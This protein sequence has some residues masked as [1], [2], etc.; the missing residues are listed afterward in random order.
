MKRSVFIIAVCSLFLNACNN[1][2]P[3]IEK[4]KYDNI[5]AYGIDISHHQDKII[6]DLNAND[7][8]TFV[9]CKASEG[10][11][12][13]DPNFSFNWKHIK[14]RNL[15][16]GAYHFYH[17]GDDPIAQA[18]FYLSKIKNLDEKDLPPILDIEDGGIDGK[19]KIKDLQ[20]DILQ[21]LQYIEQKTGRRPMIYTNL[22]FA[23]K[24]LDNKEF[25]KYPLWIAEYSGKEKPDMPKLWREKGYSF[26]QKSQ[27]YT[28]E[29]KVSDFDVFINTRKELLNKGF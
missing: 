9:I 10:E 25:V 16:R 24:Y 6:N 4:P 5:T 2:K 7:A 23:N 3:I 1:D 26:W 8:L 18:D 27:T 20:K 22:H 12:Y 17:S 13:T 15:V 29:S 14:I 28:V 21:Y 19:I 11:D